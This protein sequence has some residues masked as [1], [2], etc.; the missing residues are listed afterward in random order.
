MGTKQ[1]GSV[2]FATLLGACNLIARYNAGSRHDGAVGDQ[3]SSDLSVSD[4]GN[5][6]GP[7]RE[8]AGSPPVL[9]IG[10]CSRDGW[11]WLHPLPQ[12][13]PLSAVYM[14]ST[15]EAFAVGLAGT[16]VQWVGGTWSSLPDN[17]SQGRPTADLT[18][19][20]GDQTHVLAGGLNGVVYRHASGQWKEPDDTRVVPVVGLV[21]TNGTVRVVGGEVGG[22][23]GLAQKSPQSNAWAEFLPNMS[24]R[25]IA[26]RTDSGGETTSFVA[27]ETGA[28]HALLELSSS[29]TQSALAQLSP[30]PLN[31]LWASPTEVIAVGDKGLVVKIASD[32]QNQHTLPGQPPLHT[33]WGADNGAVFVAGDNALW[34]RESPNSNW[35]D[36]TPRVG[37]GV[38]RGIHGT[39]D[40]QAMMLVGVGGEILLSDDKTTWQRLDKRQSTATFTA[41][42][43]HGTGVRVGAA[44]GTIRDSNADFRQLQLNTTEPILRLATGTRGSFALLAKDVL[45]LDG[46]ANLGGLS[47]TRWNDILIPQS[48][49]DVAA[50]LVGAGGT[51]GIIGQDGTTSR[52]SSS[53]RGNMLALCEANGQIYFWSQLDDRIAIGHMSGLTPT[54]THI[55]WDNL[56]YDGDDWTMFACASDATNDVTFF[57]ASGNAL[58]YVRLSELNA[59][60]T[61]VGVPTSG[62]S[63]RALWAASADMCYIVGDRGLILRAQVVPGAI[64]VEPLES[65]TRYDLTAIAGDTSRVVAVGAHGTVLQLANDSSKDNP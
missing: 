2:V 54:D 60:A 4:A 7:N 22:L 53:G 14:R 1:I 45:S 62:R 38:Y 9:P 23:A 55:E 10:A 24:G 47:G 58:T 59:T 21:E 39:P 32:S 42:V 41:V 33:V 26:S 48:V 16:V 15:S 12:G 5:D 29:G 46:S 65:G 13:N 49:P 11:C 17:S 31:A 64:D 6:D 44:D 37:S 56:G 52:S 19:I 36:W 57:A 20:W 43:V 35:E 27:V 18:S 63:V 30:Q 40:G 61:A 50:L 3:N 8:D 28:S 51:I 25:A 34:R